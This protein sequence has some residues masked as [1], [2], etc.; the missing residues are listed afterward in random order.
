MEGGGDD[1][2]RM[3]G[4]R[5]SLPAAVALVL[6]LPLPGAA[7][8]TA[9]GNRQALTVPD[10]AVR[11]LA[12]VSH[13]LGE[14][15]G[16]VVVFCFFRTDL[17]RSVKA[18]NGLT[19]VVGAFRDRNMAPFAVALPGEDSMEGLRSLQGKLGL[20]YPVLLDEGKRLS[21][22][23]GV[24]ALPTTVLVDTGGTVA[25]SFTQYSVDFEEALAQG[26][27][28]VLGLPGESAAGGRFSRGEQAALTPAAREAERDLLL[29]QTLQQKGFPARALP[30]AEKALQKDPGLWKAHLLMGK[31]LL[32]LGRPESARGHFESV[33]EKRVDVAEARVG[34]GVVFLSSGDLD[35]A[36]AEF[37]RAIAL[38]DSLGE[39]WYHLGQVQEKRGMAARALESYRKAC[40]ELIRKAG[41]SE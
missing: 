9:N 4:V 6:L 28:D 26:I 34:L 1:A 20:A 12:G 8:T 39:A 40:A 32:D 37:G 23:L 14:L 13:P 18:L 24:T 21:S 22:A 35:R 7:A 3:R 31:A 16:K 27:R 11:D 15:R 2:G 38:D 41:G 10:M 36:E 30:E 19:K 29:A 17:D 33:L 5:G 25:G